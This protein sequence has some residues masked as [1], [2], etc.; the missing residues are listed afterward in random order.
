MSVVLE[1]IISIAVHV[2]LCVTSSLASHIEVKE[3]QMGVFWMFPISSFRMTGWNRVSLPYELIG[4]Y[5]YFWYSLSIRS[6][7]SVTANSVSFKSDLD[8][9]ATIFSLPNT[10]AD[11]APHPLSK[12]ALRVMCMGMHSTTFGKGNKEGHA[13]ERSFWV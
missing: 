5:E 13:L 7:S 10:C 11:F 6:L 8:C 4:L 3:E 1:E 2:T 12:T 9:A